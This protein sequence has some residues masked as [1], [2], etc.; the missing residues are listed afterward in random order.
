MIYVTVINS[1]IND[2]RSHRRVMNR[3]NLDGGDAEG[4]LA[5]G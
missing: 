1:R 3:I 4:T 2:K 5:K